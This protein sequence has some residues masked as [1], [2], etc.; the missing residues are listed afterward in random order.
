MAIVISI[1][2]W[3][4]LLTTVPLKWHPRHIYFV[5]TKYYFITEA[6]NTSRMW[7]AR[8]RHATGTRISNMTIWNWRRIAGIPD[9]NLFCEFSK[10]THLCYSQNYLWSKINVIDYNKL[11]SWQVPLFSLFRWHK[12]T[13]TLNLLNFS[14]QYIF[15]TRIHIQ[16][17]GYSQVC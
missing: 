11:I 3:S 8:L 15:V 16:N 13:K 10:P 14:F 6:A 5:F 7:C 2:L 1:L 9:I 12:T 4:R 17:E